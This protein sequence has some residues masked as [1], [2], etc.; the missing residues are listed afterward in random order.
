[1][2]TSSQA[3]LVTTFDVDVDVN[4]NMNATVDFDDPSTREERLGAVLGIQGSTSTSRV[5]LTFRFKS[6]SSSNDGWF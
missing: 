5:A 1:V 6:T 3:P 2:A 4:L